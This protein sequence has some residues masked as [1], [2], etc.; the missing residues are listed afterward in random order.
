MI[1]MVILRPERVSSRPCSETNFEYS[2]DNSSQQHVE[3]ESSD[4]FV[5]SLP[6]DDVFPSLHE[7]ANRPQVTRESAGEFVSVGEG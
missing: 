4:A 7:S 3:F 6:A 1:C 5:G 2:R